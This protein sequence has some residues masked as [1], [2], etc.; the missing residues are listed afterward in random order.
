ML[1]S[2]ETSLHG[3]VSGAGFP[4]GPPGFKAGVP[5]PLAL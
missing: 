4:V 2:K 3:G 1:R 5:H